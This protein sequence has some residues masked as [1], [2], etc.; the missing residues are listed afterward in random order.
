MENNKKD[1][2]FSLSLILIGLYVTV[3]GLRMYKKASQPPYNIETLS[4]SPAFLP[5]ILGVVLVLLSVILFVKSLK[6][7]SFNAQLKVLAASLQ[8]IKGNQD[9]KAMFVGTLI[10]AI[11]T[12][13]L[14]AVLPFWIASILFLTALMFY[15][16]A[17]KFW[18]ILLISALSIGAVV[19]LFQ[20]GFNAALP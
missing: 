14:M 12:F 10:L 2:T 17:G 18:K 4:I 7:T 6:G 5:M 20:V 8:G 19:L 13:L 1:F 3:E 9:M 11:Y 15:L 16:K